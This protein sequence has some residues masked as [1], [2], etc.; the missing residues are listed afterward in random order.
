MGSKSFHR[1][2]MTLL[3]AFLTAFCLAC[4]GPA[5]AALMVIEVS[6]VA[7]SGK[8]EQGPWETKLSK[9]FLDNGTFLRTLEGTVAC[10][11]GTGAM[12]TL[13]PR[14]LA[15]VEDD[16]LRAING[17]IG[18]KTGSLLS[19]VM[20]YIRQCV[21]GDSGSVEAATTSGSKASDKTDV[22]GG[23]PVARQKP[24][25]SASQTIMEEAIPTVQAAPP[26]MSEM[27]KSSAD[28]ETMWKDLFVSEGAS[29][30]ETDSMETKSL[31]GFSDMAAKK[32][33][34]SRELPSVCP[35]IPVGSNRNTGPYKISSGEVLLLM[36]L[37]ATGEIVVT[38]ES[39][40]LK[41][42]VYKGNFPA[43]DGAGIIKVNLPF[44]ESRTSGR[45]TVGFVASGS[46]VD[47]R[48]DLE[49][50]PANLM[51]EVN[52]KA[53]EL[54]AEMDGFGIHTRLGARAALLQSIGFLPDAL[55][56]FREAAA[57]DAEVPSLF[58]SLSNGLME[59]MISR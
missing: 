23:G 39:A 9:G 12:K 15:V 27:S 55:G 14:S 7:H 51:A 38:F 56:L 25:K 1:S 37:G 10:V 57:R 46:A 18:E 8:G 49:T 4:Q 16:S 54:D 21:S 26:S 59:R 47:S 34:T 40:G 2:S 41:D 20:G 52:E 17:K 53:R 13:G 36:P 33:A 44:T 45:M 42:F 48:V 58:E 24:M 28:S 30:A 35:V 43:M 5:M 22:M 19:S 50:I 11:E 32:E 31:P 3:T 6:G 29:R